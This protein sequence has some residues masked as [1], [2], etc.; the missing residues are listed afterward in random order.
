MVLRAVYSRSESSA[1][2]FAA[3]AQS[4]LNSGEIPFYHDEGGAETSLD[5]L[6]ARDDVAFVIV[7]LPINTQPEVIVRALKAGKHVLSEKPIARDVKS[8]LELIQ[9]YEE[10]YK[11]KGLSWRV[12]ENFEAEPAYL[13]AKCAQDFLQRKPIVSDKNYY[14]KSDC[15]WKNR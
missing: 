1:R 5:A 11:P 2:T 9:T 14:Q 7:V 4:N 6:L 12:A 8:A 10:V 3:F 15:R 13:E